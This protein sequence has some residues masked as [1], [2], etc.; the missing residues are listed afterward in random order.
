MAKPI[1]SGDPHLKL[2]GLGEVP[3]NPKGAKIVNLNGETNFLG[4]IVTENR[5]YPHIKLHG[6]A[7]GSK[8][9][10]T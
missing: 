3:W 2:H 5:Y 9:T 6:L 7:E 8:G 4:R 10:K 1:I